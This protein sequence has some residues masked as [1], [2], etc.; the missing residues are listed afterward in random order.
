M[1][2]DLLIRTVQTRMVHAITHSIP[3][4]AELPEADKLWAAEESVVHEYE[5]DEVIPSTDLAAPTCHIILS[6]AAEMKTAD[7]QQLLLSSGDLFGSVS[8][9]I[10]LPSDAEIRASER[11]LVCEI[12]ENIFITFM[13]VYASFEQNVI[14]AGEQRKTSSCN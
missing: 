14:Q 11:A 3:A 6:G 10:E 9:H 2:G 13:N 7:G 5:P 1:A 12:P 4:F 8:P